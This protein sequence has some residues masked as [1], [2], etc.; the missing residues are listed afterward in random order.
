MWIL[1][2]GHEAVLRFFGTQKVASATLKKH[3]KVVDVYASEVVQTDF[4]N[5]QND[6]SRDKAELCQIR[7]KND[8][9]YVP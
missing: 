7:Q 8:V 3:C 9:L 1:D 2:H 6:M 4:E 5:V